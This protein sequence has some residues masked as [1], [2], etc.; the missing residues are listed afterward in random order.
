MP[1]GRKPGT[2]NAAPKPEKVAPPI[3]TTLWAAADKLRGNMDAGEYKHVALG[4]IFLKYISDRFDARRKAALT[5]PEERDLVDDRDLYLADGI[6]YVPDR[7]RWDFLKE[8]ATSTKPTVGELLD[9]AMLDIEAENS[10]LR[11]VLTKNYARQELDQTKLGEVL[12]LFSDIKFDDSHKGQDVLG[13]VYEYFLGEFAK[14]EGKR[15]GQYYTAG[16]VVKLLVEM[17]E[18]F[19]GRVYDPC[20]GSGG[21]FVQSERFVEEHGGRLNEISVYGQESNATTW[22]LAKMNLAIRSI[23]ANLGPKWADTF[24]EDLHKGLMAKYVLANPPFNDSDWGGEKLKDDGRWKYGVPPAGNA[25]F[26]WLQHIVHH[27]AP[28]G[29][30]GVVLANGSLSS[31]QF[32]EGDIRRT[33]IEGIEVAEPNGTKTV[34]PGLVD[35]IVALPGQLF[36]TTQIPVCLWFLTRD[37]SNGISRDKKLRDRTGEILFIDARGLGTMVSRTL[38]ELSDDDIAKVANTYHAW[39]EVGGRY[40][41]V[42]GF[43][44]AASLKEVEAQGFLLTP[45]RYVGT[46]EMDPDD[47]PF[48]SKISRLTKDLRD[49]MTEG[50]ALDER[51]RN[52]LAGVGHGW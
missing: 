9:Q 12:K 32:G 45:G 37:K 25:N 8:N 11:G 38:K 23:E 42:P 17:L 47:E 7:S 48:E 18:P 50:M 10:S 15:G 19:K 33:M 51:I 4:L 21:M 52:A 20:C 30:A 14:M 36:S 6:F 3:A 5:D 46:R 43:A 26:A 28:D 40:V 34:Y 39:R 44:K 49:Q 24:H 41:D 22:R 35:C 31:Q 16:C 2:K 27:L 1:R 29:Y 13:R